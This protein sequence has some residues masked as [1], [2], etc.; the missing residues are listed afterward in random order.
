M[1]S[2]KF[3]QLLRNPGKEPRL[4]PPV[5]TALYTQFWDLFLWVCV[6]A[7]F[8]ILSHIMPSPL[9]VWSADQQQQM[10]VRNMGSQALP[11]GS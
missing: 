10:C 7:K 3:P 6:R 8:A 1:Q 11:T 9:T 5:I 2:L 4:Q